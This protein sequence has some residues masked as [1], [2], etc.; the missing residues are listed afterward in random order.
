MTC[1]TVW[2]CSVPLCA[3]LMRTS[4]RTSVVR[5]HGPEVTITPVR[6]APSD[7]LSESRSIIRSSRQPM[8]AMSGR[9]AGAE[10]LVA[11]DHLMQLVASVDPSQRRTPHGR[12]QGGVASE[13][14]EGGGRGRRI[15]DAGDDAART[16]VAIAV[17]SLDELEARA[18]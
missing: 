4:T 8:P 2:T 15:R 7:A 11:R 6:N 9:H 18:D 13:R 3:A 10:G 1:S 5:S 16:E 12:S 14:D 17:A